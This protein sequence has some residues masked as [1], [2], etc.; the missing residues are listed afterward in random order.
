[1]TFKNQGTAYSSLRALITHAN[2]PPDLRGYWT[3]VHE[4][5]IRRRGIIDDVHAASALP[6]VY[7]L[8][9]AEATFKK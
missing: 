2:A 3:K 4:I 7:Q 5:F 6:S 8:S 9:N 1:M